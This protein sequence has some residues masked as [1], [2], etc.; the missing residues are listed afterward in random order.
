MKQKYKLLVLHG[1]NLNLLGLREPEIYGT[2]TLKD[3]NNNLM[4]LGA[5]H[6]ANIEC[7]QSNS[8]GELIDKTQSSIVEQYDFIIVNPAGLTHTSI[9]WRDAFL[10]QKSPF[11][12]V[13]ISNVYARETFRHKSYFSDIA[14][15][16]ISGLGILGYELALTYIFRQLSHKE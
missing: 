4:N 9:A 7:F 5:T 16:V 15:A 2:T 3:I 10:S 12:E 14:T 11:I 1:P 6:N 8:E 13:H